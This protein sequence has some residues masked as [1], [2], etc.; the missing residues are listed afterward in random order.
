MLDGLDSRAAPVCSLLRSA[1]SDCVICG[2]FIPGMICWPRQR[3]PRLWALPYLEVGPPRAAFFD[4][5]RGGVGG[6]RL[7][8][9]G[10]EPDRPGGGSMLSFPITCVHVR[11]DAGIR[12]QRGPFAAG[13]PAPLFA[14]GM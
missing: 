7:H 11:S 3:P 9:R 1:C 10:L 8:G 4:C 14:A 5:S 12:A 6:E 13:L 2:G